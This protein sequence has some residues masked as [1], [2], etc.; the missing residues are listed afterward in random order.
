MAQT[1]TLEKNKGV[2]F[3]KSTNSS[4]AVAQS[5]LTSVM[6]L[7]I[8]ALER[9][10]IQVS[11]IGRALDQFQISFRS[12]SDAPYSL[13][14]SSAANFTTPQGIV[15]GASGDLT[16]LAASTTGWVIIDVQSFHDIK[17]EASSAHSDGS[18]VSVYLG[19][20]S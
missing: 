14:L 1:Q 11:V 4:V 10:F 6:E 8:S 19:G 2:V 3:Y 15:V 20:A 17:I 7:N 18:T 12:N 16:A 9:I 13:M 5:G